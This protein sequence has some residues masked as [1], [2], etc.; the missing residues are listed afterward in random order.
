MIRTKF[1]DPCWSMTFMVR[2]P[3][4]FPQSMMQASHQNAMHVRAAWS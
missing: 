4:S 2:P 1:C 3:F